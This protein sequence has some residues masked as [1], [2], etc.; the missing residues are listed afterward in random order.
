LIC[1]SSAAA[2]YVVAQYRDRKSKQDYYI[3]VE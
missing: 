2:G 1:I 3:A